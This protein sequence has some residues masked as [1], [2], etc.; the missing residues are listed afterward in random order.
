[1]NICFQIIAFLHAEIAQVVAI[2]ARGSRRTP[3]ILILILISKNGCEIIHIGLTL[4]GR[5]D[6]SFHLPLNCLDNFI[7][8]NK[9][10]VLWHLPFICCG[11]FY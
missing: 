5:Y 10:T 4:H 2:Y 9:N 11:L 8:A 6:T 3:L 1:M 7:Q